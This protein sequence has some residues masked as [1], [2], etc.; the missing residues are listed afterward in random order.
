MKIISEKTNK[1]YASVEECLAAEKEFDDAIA[2][3]KA[4]KEKALVEA[5]AKK[6]QLA[7][8]RKERAA[9]VE[10][11][12]KAVTEAQKHF[13]EVLNAFTKDYGSFH[14]TLRTGDGNPFDLF[15]HFFDNFWL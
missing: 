8:V 3:E 7:A 14:M 6:E 12:Y 15:N 1:E 10:A 4:A 2:A 5:K 11:A 9:E 13:R